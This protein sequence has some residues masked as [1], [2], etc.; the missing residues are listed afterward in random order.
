M[1][2]CVIGV[3]DNIV[4]QHWRVPRGTKNMT[5]MLILFGNVGIPV[6]NVFPVSQIWKKQRICSALLVCTFV[7]ALTYRIQFNYLLTSQWSNQ[8]MA[9]PEDWFKSLTPVA[10]VWLSIAVITTFGA[11]FGFINLA[12]LYFDPLLI[13]QKFQVI[14]SMM[15]FQSMNPFTGRVLWHNLNILALSA[16]FGTDYRFGD[17]LRHFS[18]SANWDFRGWYRCSFSPNTHKCSKQVQSSFNASKWLNFIQIPIDKFIEWIKSLI[19]SL[20]DHFQ[21]DA[22]LAEMVFLLMFGSVGLIAF[23]WILFSGQIPFLG[24]GLSFTLLYVWSRKSPYIDVSFWGFQFKAWHLPFV[25]LVFTF[26]MGQ[27]PMLD[28]FGVLV[29]HSYHFIMDIVPRVYGKNLMSCPQFLYNIFDKTE[30]QRDNWRGGT[31]HRLQWIASQP[32]WFF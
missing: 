20:T 21:G 9:G 5:G 2:A 16:L 26:I 17:W 6:M 30:A 11:Q 27:N 13:Y 23:N 29:G 28:I 31:A 25:L 12:Y 32:V 14:P 22:G 24:S 18:I 19:L 10:K 8:S 1:F 4:L 7:Q 15:W 3:F